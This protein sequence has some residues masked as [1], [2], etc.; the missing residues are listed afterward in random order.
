MVD[1]L[2]HRQLVGF[3]TTR[4]CDEI[5][6]ASG[7]R[8]RRRLE[9]NLVAPWR[10]RPRAEPRR[11]AHHGRQSLN[12]FIQ[13]GTTAHEHVLRTAGSSDGQRG[14]GALAASLAPPGAKALRS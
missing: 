13:P 2:F 5:I 6:P 8:R 14:G 9:P 12:L 11:S 1:S 7:W 3:G 10:P 4:G